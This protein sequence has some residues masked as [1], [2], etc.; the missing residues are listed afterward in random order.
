[1]LCIAFFFLGKRGRESYP[2][3]V[4]DVPL[5]CM[6]LGRTSS[7][8]DTIWYHQ[9]TRKFVK[10]L[11]DQRAL[12]WYVLFP[13]N[14]CLELKGKTAIVICTG[15]IGDCTSTYQNSSLYRDKLLLRSVVRLSSG[16]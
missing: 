7:A 13:F 6:D 3:Q 16:P 10:G 15:R 9:R 8:R 14:S 11:K 2:C 1:M 4:A 12:K 5:L